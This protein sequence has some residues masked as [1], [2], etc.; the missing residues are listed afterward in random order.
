[1][2]AHGVALLQLDN[3]HAQRWGER[4]R[5]LLKGSPA[6]SQMRQSSPWSI[7]LEDATVI[8]NVGDAVRAVVCLSA[9]VLRIW[10]SRDG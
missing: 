9:V 1:M 10:N 3:R 5:K 7:E 6:L 2:S 8:L 4:G